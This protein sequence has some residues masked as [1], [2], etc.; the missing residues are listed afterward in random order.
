MARKIGSAATTKPAGAPSP[1]GKNTAALDVLHPERQALIAG[2]LVEIREYG[3]IE[4]LK[5]Q[6]GCKAFLDALYELFSTADEP[7]SVDDVSDLIGAH[8]ITV[9]WLMAQAITPI[10]A[11][12]QAFVDGVHANAGWIGSLSDIDGDLLT[13]RWWEVNAGF[14]TRRLQ[15]RLLGRLAAA[16][17]AN[18][19]PSSASTTA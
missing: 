8:I 4:G 10:D 11:D 18:P 14:F 5:L 12:P 2:R 16:R 15:R 17:R 6:P 1:A 7:P 19:S 13:F 9:Q 3:Y